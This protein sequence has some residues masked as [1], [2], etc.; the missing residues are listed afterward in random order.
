MRSV[1]MKRP[2][3]LAGACALL[4]WHAAAH[5]A[6]YPTPAA[7]P[8]P[9]PGEAG[10]P[11]PPPGAASPAMPTGPSTAG[12][13]SGPG[14]PGGPNTPTG[15]SGGRG[16]KGASTPTFGPNEVVDWKLWWTF[17]RDE[18]LELEKHLAANRTPETDQEFVGTS[19]TRGP[20]LPEQRRVQTEVV[21]AL[22]RCLEGERN[23]DVLTAVSIALAKIGR[24][25]AP[26][27]AA[28]ITQAL[29]PFLAD[30]SQ[31]V[32]ETAA[33]SLGLLGGSGA[34]QLL[35]DVA[36]DAPAARQR[37]GG[38]EIPYRTRAFAT[39]GLGLFGQRAQNTD[40]RRFV[41][42]HLRRLY[43]VDQGATR[44]VRT[45][46][47]V[48]LS[49]V[50][51]APGAQA[52]PAS[53]SAAV[54][55]DAQLGWLL[56]IWNDRRESE[57]LRAFAATSAALLAESATQVLQEP[58]EHALCEALKPGSRPTAVL[59]QSAALALGRLGDN[60]DE[61]L[62]ERIRRVLQRCVQ[63]GDPLARR[64]AL[65]SLARVGARQGT[66]P[67]TVENLLA[68]RRFLL[69]ELERASSPMRPWLALA[70]GV[71][72]AQRLR[73]GYDV[74]G[75]VQKV[76]AKGLAA[77]DS[78]NE[79]GAWC[80]AAGLARCEAV[81]D[82][83]V[84]EA[85]D[86]RD[87]ETQPH[88]ALGLGLLGWDG[89]VISLRKVLQDARYRPFVLRDTSIALGMLGSSEAVSGLIDMLRT[90]ESLS[91]QSAIAEALGHVG[92]GRA[93]DPL[94]ALLRKADEPAR[95]RAFAA[96]ALGGVCDREPLP[97]NA[98]IAASVNYWVP[99]ATLYEPVSG[100]GI[101]DLL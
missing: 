29:T 85:R 8:P 49:L 80:L 71:G 24:S 72:E 89:A 101:L 55:L 81:R 18:F 90:T 30:P 94:L 19:G 59:E 10:R 39:Y 6:V 74:A 64:F 44:D 86:D 38:G 17:H 52:A 20:A 9:Q 32:A 54:T 79:K 35:V 47:L 50:P 84:A 93:L 66:G 78:P 7:P 4:C 31:E 34:L 26:A 70:L 73:A 48:A 12:A 14:G 21:P 25:A 100:T 98:P 69:Q 1:P 40:V 63:D 27:Q 61:E 68:V 13:P 41:V 76:L 92:D 36:A 75:E 91:V 67:R 43:E 45:A 62:D 15:T 65:I 95:V 83:L 28:A 88:A 23:A 33:L 16:G 60:D 56:A 57:L 37:L 82:A 58:W 77:H 11:V 97:W 87:A 96:A 2:L 46:A 42:H 51:L 3:L 53:E 99:P 22:L 5:G